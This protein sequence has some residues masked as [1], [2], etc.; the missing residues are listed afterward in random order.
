MKNELHEMEYEDAPSGFVNLYNYKEPFMKFE[1]EFGGFGYQGVLLFD[2]KTQKIQCHFCGEWL[3]YLPHHIK[4][5]HN[6]KAAEYKKIV[7]LNK[8]SALISE[9]HREL[10]VEK[11]LKRFNN[12]RPGRKKTDDEKQKI[13]A[14]RKENQRESQNKSG[15]CPA[16]LIDRLRKLSETLGHPPTRREV[17]FIETLKLVYG[18]FNNAMRIAQLPTRKPG[19]K[20]LYDEQTLLTI[21]AS[22][23]T[24]YGR[25]PSGSD[26]RRKLLPNKKLYIKNFGSMEKAIDNIN[27]YDEAGSLPDFRADE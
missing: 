11:G 12:L 10:L 7:G 9:K 15:T 22:F 25:E 24:E 8:T 2:G 23:V 27:K 21:L 5:E 16:Q 1:S 26:F 14:S 3:N 18:S 20:V 19:G 4:K 13:S 17:P 6:I